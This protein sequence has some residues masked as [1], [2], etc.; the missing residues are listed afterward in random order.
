MKRWLVVPIGLGLA[1]VA[2]WVL[3]SSPT[4]SPPVESSQGHAEIDRQSREQL[5][6]I[7]RK[8]DEDPR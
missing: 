7:L 3:L 2:G 8:A 4:G 1:V 6:E 5:R